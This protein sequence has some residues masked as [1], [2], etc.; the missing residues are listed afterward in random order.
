V[1]VGISQVKATRS[2]RRN[3][4]HE[5]CPDG[6]VDEDRSRCNEH[7]EAHEAIGLSI[8]SNCNLHTTSILLHTMVK[9]CGGLNE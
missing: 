7:G 8:V 2:E 9:S 3:P 4:Y 5:Q 6:V 1:L